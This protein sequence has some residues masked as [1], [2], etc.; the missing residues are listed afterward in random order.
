MSAERK[1][2]TRGP[3]FISDPYDNKPP[4]KCRGEAFPDNRQ[5]PPSKPVEV[6]RPNKESPPKCTLAAPAIELTL[7]LAEA[8]R[9]LIRLRRKR[10]ACLTCPQAIG[11][12][13][14]NP[15]HTLAAFSAAIG[16]AINELW[17]EWGEK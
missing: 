17:E 8:Q 12:C 1:I 7:L 9:S 11:D 2:S 13:S 16:A 5:D 10:R 4:T 3:L 6:L 14:Q 15:C